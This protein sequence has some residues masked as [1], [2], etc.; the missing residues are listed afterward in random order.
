MQMRFI[1]QLLLTIVKNSEFVDETVGNCNEVK[2]TCDMMPENTLK[3][4]KIYIYM[5]R[6]YLMKLHQK[7]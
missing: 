1:I 5:S 6:L 3:L 7:R 4:A 2:Y